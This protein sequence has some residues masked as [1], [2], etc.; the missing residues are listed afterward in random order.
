MKCLAATLVL[1]AVAL[2]TGFLAN[3]ADKDRSGGPM[4]IHDV[5]FS[6]KDN[7]PQAKAKL[8]GACK[9]YLSNHPGTVFFATGTLAEDLDRPVND[10]DWDVSLHIAFKDKASHDQYQ[11]A[12]RHKKFIEENRDNWKKVRVFDSKADSANVK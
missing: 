1:L 3:A 5:Y 10:R 11:S 9:K 12:E 7:S 4:V 6:L 2:V 8:V